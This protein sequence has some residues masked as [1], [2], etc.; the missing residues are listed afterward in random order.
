MQLN[1]RH[2]DKF[3]ERFEY[4]WP[5]ARTQ[6]TRFY[7]D[8][9]TKTLA[10]TAP[11][12]PTA[13]CYLPEGEGIT[14]MSAPLTEEME[15]AGPMAAKLFVSSKSED[16]DMFV[17]LRV[18]RP[19][20]SEL[21]FAGSNDPRTPIALGWLRASHRKL[22]P[23]LTLPFRPYHTHDEKQPLV[24]DEAVE[25]DVEIWPSGMVIPAG[26]RIGLTVRGRDY[27]HPGEP[28]RIPGIGY[29][30]AGVGPFVHTHPADRPAAI[31]NAQVTLHADKT[32]QPF[33]LLPL[34]PPKG[35]V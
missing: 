10:A 3:V 20:G 4:E 21:T 33:V 12:K 19:D 28:I 1:V 27:R 30:M 2:V 23:K 11:T 15:I 26:Y 7:L 13:L 31:F 16:A 18:F 9:E 24:P 32:R 25:L 6:W 5:I 35:K 14:F 22:D 29:E 8:L 34:I 17:A